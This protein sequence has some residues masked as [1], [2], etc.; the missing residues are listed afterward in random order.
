MPSENVQPI[1]RFKIVREL[2]GLTQAEFG[3]KLGFKLNKIRD[4]EI[5]KQKISPEIAIDIENKFSIAFK[6]LLTG[7][8]SMTANQV[9]ES[10]P[11]QLGAQDLDPVTAKITALLADMAED[12][13]RD[14][15]K[16]VE[17]RKLLA[18]IKRKAG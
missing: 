15:L 5:G 2:L 6:W 18:E 14:V 4:I 16:Y 7:M 3:E 12:Q 17:E 8:G 1:N 13:R 9:Q 11:Y 10:G